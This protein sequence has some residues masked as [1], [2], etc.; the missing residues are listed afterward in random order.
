MRKQLRCVSLLVASAF[1]ITAP[2]GC[3][4]RH[5]YPV[6]PAAGA[7]GGPCRTGGGCDPG[8]M[9]NVTPNV[10]GPLSSGQAL[11]VVIAGDIAQAGRTV[12]A[13]DNAAVITAYPRSVE[14]LLLLGDNARYG[15]SGGLL[16]Y[17]NTYYA[18]VTEANWGQFDAR[19]FPLPGNHE[20]DEANAQGYFDYF[21]ERMNV[22]SALS[23]YHGFI[24]I[25]GKGYY[26][27]DLNGWH[28]VGLNSNCQDVINGGCD[29]GSEQETWLRNDLATHVG[30]PI[31]AGWHAPRY[32]CGGEHG[33]DRAV[34]AFW[35]D[36]FDAGADF[37]FAGHNHY[38]QRFKPL[39]KDSPEATVD[40]A[41]GLTQIV[42]G[43][44]GVTT[45][46][47]C[48]SGDSRVANQIGGDAGMGVLF[49][50][51]RTDGTYA[52]EYRLRDGST[53]DFGAGAS[54]HASK[55]PND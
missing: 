30:M 43:S 50:T 34:Q 2:A 38:Y 18:P 6:V 15:G 4:N 7:E 32:T 23:S 16:R 54:H 5:F 25:I 20:Y 53:F 39:N 24:N 1:F 33:D 14:A 47:V 26:S 22:I 46:A 40:R 8:L 29:Q 17:F 48:G 9:C 44:T 49:L 35:A 13:W 3:G 51:I 31:V 41:N 42:V 11:T 10:C 21:A 37:V 19:A 55:I 12:Y 28:F 45:Y 52:F 27:F 36:L